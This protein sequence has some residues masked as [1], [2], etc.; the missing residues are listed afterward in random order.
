MSCARQLICMVDFKDED[1][2]CVFYVSKPIRHLSHRLRA[3]LPVLNEPVYFDQHHSRVAACLSSPRGKKGLKR[4]RPAREA[5][6]RQCRSST[7]FLW[8]WRMPAAAELPLRSEE[9]SEG[10]GNGQSVLY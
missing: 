3:R 2:D 5:F 7:D 9:I 10:E 6:L 1:T 8:S 4:G